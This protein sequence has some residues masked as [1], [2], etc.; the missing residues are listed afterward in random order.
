MPDD[1]APDLSE[2]YS[3]LVQR[4][5]ESCEMVDN[6][7]IAQEK[8][9]ED[10]NTTEEQRD[11]LLAEYSSAVTVR[12]RLYEEMQDKSKLEE[13]RAQHRPIT[14]DGKVARVKEP[15]VYRED[16]VHEISFFRDLYNAQLKNDPAA[17]DRINRHQQHEIEKRAVTSSTLGGIIPAQYLVD[18]YAKASRNGRVFADQVNGQTLPDVG[19][20]L[21]VPRLTQGLSAA[22]QTTQNT[23]VVTQDP[24]ETD[25]TVNVNTIAGYSPVSRQAIERAAYSDRILFE[26]LTARYWAVL[27]TYCING[28]GSNNQPLG[29][30]GTSSIST[31]AAS[32]MT[33]AGI[34][35]KIADIIQQIAVAVGGLGYG[36]TKI[37]MHPRRWGFF[38]ASVDSSNR[39]LIVPSGP[40]F[41]AMG[42]DNN[43]EADVGLVGNMHGIPVYVDPNIPTNLGTNTNEDR[44][45]AIAHP[46]VHLWERSNDPVTLSF[47]QQAGTSLQV[48]LVCYGYVAFTAGRYPAASGV[49]TGLTPPTF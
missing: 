16:N 11:K 46:I 30:L 6:A 22:A 18:L 38:E 31:S 32:T 34:Y 4:Y 13:A 36:A 26:D 48:Q 35:P 8:A 40:G 33:A 39:P 2:K 15:D 20:S 12:D 27:D 17:Q 28:S 41:N 9:R 24:T 29:L 44:I 14:F 1:Q 23:A 45:I 47:E 10:A 3:G 43:P 25:L 5:N 21:V 19:M 49:V 37:F 7:F 42:T